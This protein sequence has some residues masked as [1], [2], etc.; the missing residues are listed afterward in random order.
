MAPDV[1]AYTLLSLRAGFQKE[2]GLHASRCCSKMAK[3][4]TSRASSRFEGA[5]GNLSSMR[6]PSC[7]FTE[8]KD[9]GRCGVRSGN[10]RENSCSSSL[11]ICC[12]PSFFP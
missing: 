6:A 8:D 1:M 5:L 12:L 9:G 4:M 10:R 2:V 7:S 3:S 11:A